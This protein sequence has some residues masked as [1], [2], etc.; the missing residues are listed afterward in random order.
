MDAQTTNH[1]L[2][3]IHQA[4]GPIDTSILSTQAWSLIAIVS[5][6]L[7]GALVWFFIYKINKNKP[8]PPLSPYEQAQRALLA[9]QSL[10]AENPKKFANQLSSTLRSYIEV[11]HKMPAIG[12]TTQEFINYIQVHQTIPYEETQTLEAIFETCDKTQFTSEHISQ[13]ELHKTYNQTIDFIELNNGT[14]DLA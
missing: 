9:A 11:T 8:L 1:A 4:Y 2:T 5:L 13:D 7:V 12:Q 14:S 6:I 10:Q 3:D